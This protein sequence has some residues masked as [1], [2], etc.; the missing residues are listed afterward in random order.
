MA[1]QRMTPHYSYFFT[2]SP[3]L[4]TVKKRWKSLKIVRWN[5]FSEHFRIEF[6]DGRKPSLFGLLKVAQFAWSKLEKHS[7]VQGDVV[8]ENLT[9]ALQPERFFSRVGCWQWELGQY[10]IFHVWVEIRKVS[11]QRTVSV[12]F[13]WLAELSFLLKKMH[14]VWWKRF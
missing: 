11:L 2:P 4:H 7:F 6:L 12:I 8:G 3:C 13:K 9:G 14:F 5:S 1:W 10:M